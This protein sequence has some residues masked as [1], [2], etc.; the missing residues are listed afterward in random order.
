M[1]LMRL[2]KKHHFNLM[3]E[4]GF[5]GATCGERHPHSAAST[6]PFL[7]GIMSSFDLIGS[8]ISFN[9]RVVASKLN[10]ELNAQQKASELVQTGPQVSDRVSH[11]SNL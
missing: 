11:P 7:G 4:S 3:W 8:F 10:K 6:T 1:R 2:T 9:E 5:C